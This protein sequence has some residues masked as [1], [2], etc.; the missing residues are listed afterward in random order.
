MITTPGSS[1]SSCGSVSPLRGGAVAGDHRGGGRRILAGPIGRTRAAPSRRS[2]SRARRGPR[3]ARLPHGPSSGGRAEQ[4]REH[5][6]RRW[7]WSPRRRRR[8]SDCQDVEDPSV[9]QRGVKRPRPSAP[10]SQPGWRA[11]RCHAMAGDPVA[12]EFFEGSEA[13]QARPHGHVGGCRT[14]RRHHR[15]R[16]GGLVRAGRARPAGGD[17]G[18]AA[19][20]SGRAWR[21]S[22]PRRSP[23]SG[24]PRARGAASTSPATG[25]SR[26]GGEGVRAG[27]QEL[28]GHPQRGGQHPARLLRRARRPGP[29]PS[30]PSTFTTEPSTPRRASSRW[31]RC[32]S[33]RAPSPRTTCSGG[34]PPRRTAARSPSARSWSS[35]A[36]CR[37]TPSSG[38]P[39]CRPDGACGSGRSS[40]RRASPTVRT[41]RP[42]WPS[43]RSA[44][45]ASWASC[46]WR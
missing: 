15:R 38:R 17:G 4:Q 35:S 13:T 28:R 39:S 46:W 40:C 32:W 43:R 33:R 24:S 44:R 5:A 9:P 3:P 7:L 14:G 30:R 2:R 41:S 34:W 31:A 29:A 27:W 10:A 37:W 25:R 12:K 22:P 19:R 1:D 23:T 45:A 21:A 18:R 8:A 26:I 6:E 36:G 20:A 42:P 11:C 16:P